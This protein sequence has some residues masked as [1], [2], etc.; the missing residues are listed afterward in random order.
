MIK[1][2]CVYCTRTGHTKALM[3][4]ISDKLGA[5]LV[6]ITDGKNRSGLLG[7]VSAA[8]AGLSKSLPKIRDIRTANNMG[9]YDQVI[10]GMPI[11]SE[12]TCPIA[13]A[14]LKKY[15]HDITGK[16]YYVVTHASDN[17]YERPIQKLDEFLGRP[18]EAHLS[19]SSKKSDLSG[20][21]DRFVAKVKG[22]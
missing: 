2:L 5:E 20:E 8:I 14:F 4:A 13:K 10:V 21:V 15:G 12:T 6:E 3:Q 17:L 18:H 16:V 11:W 19:V 22:N 9:E 1:V 7:Y